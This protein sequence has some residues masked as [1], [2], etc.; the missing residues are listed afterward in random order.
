MRRNLRRV[1][2]RRRDKHGRIEHVPDESGGVWLIPPDLRGGVPT[3]PVA[4]IRDHFIRKQ[5]I[6]DS[7]RHRG[8]ARRSRYSLT[9][10]PVSKR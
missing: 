9:L 7:K 3:T 8:F 10:T 6:W 5:R 1:D 2:L 4:T